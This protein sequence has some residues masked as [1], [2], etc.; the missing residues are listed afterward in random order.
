MS[1]TNPHQ[2][3]AMELRQ[4]RE[5]G[6]VVPRYRL[7]QELLTRMRNSLDA[8]IEKN[9]GTP[10]DQLFTLHLRRG[11]AQGLQGDEAWVEYMQCPPILDIVEQ[12][13]GPDF[14]LWG[15]TVFGKPAG[16]GK[17]IPWH[18]DG[19]YWPIRPLANATVWIAL[20]DCKLSNGCM[21]YIPGSHASRRLFL[22]QSVER[23]EVLLEKEVAAEEFDPSRAKDLI[24]EAGQF[25]IFD[26]FLVHGSRANHSEERR[27]AFV[28][29]FMPTTSHF[30]HALG[31]EFA[32]NTRP[33]DMGRRP[34]FLMRGVDRTG[35]NDFEIGHAET[36]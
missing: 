2:L 11:Q 6:L 14:L 33:V 30:D 28:L 12:C 8:F 4:Y 25:A 24:L 10:S 15:T 16:A 20:D 34:L 17:E 5:D 29:R 21:R 31:A 26:V 35:R 23:D 27:A 18:Q 32:R 36:R 1:T 7:P 13:L 19:E 3:S 22:H 9:P